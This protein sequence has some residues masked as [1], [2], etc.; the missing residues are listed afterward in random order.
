MCRSLHCCHFV[1]AGCVAALSVVKPCVS[2]SYLVFLHSGK[3][4]CCV[5]TSMWLKMIVKLLLLLVRSAPTRS[6]QESY[7]HADFED[8]LA[9]GTMLV[10]LTWFGNLLHLG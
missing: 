7:R 3:S 10:D 6:P 5:Q 2:P 1:E 8:I 9:T 4:P